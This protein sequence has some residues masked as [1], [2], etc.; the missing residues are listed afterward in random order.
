VP[1]GRTIV[2]S[3][4]ERH[5]SK[6]FTSSQTSKGDRVPSEEP[7]RITNLA[8][9][10]PVDTAHVNIESGNSIENGTSLKAGLSFAENC[11]GLDTQ[12]LDQSLDVSCGRLN[13][14]DASGHE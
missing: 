4:I 9:Q 14:Q 6:S 8:L 13:P 11:Y 12:R 3:E 1:F 10:L 5:P 2:D 7:D